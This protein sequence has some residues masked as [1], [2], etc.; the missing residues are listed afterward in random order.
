MPKN[1]AFETML[2]AIAITVALIFF[3]KSQWSH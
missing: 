2:I 3:L 1:Y